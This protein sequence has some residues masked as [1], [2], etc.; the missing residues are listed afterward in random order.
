MRRALL[1]TLALGVAPS[2][3]HAGDARAPRVVIDA[4]HGG[5]Q[6]GAVGV[7]GVVEK[8]VVLAVAHEAA[9]LLTDAGWEVVLTRPDDRQVGL[10]ERVRLANAAGADLFVSIHCNA[11]TGPGSRRV[12]GIETYFLSADATDEAARR[13]ARYENQNAGMAPRSADD[14]LSRILH[15]LAVSAAHEGSA[16]LAGALQE[17]L[18]AAMGWPD[19]GVRQAPFAVLNGAAMPAVLVELGFL[20]HPSEGQQLAEAATQRRLAEALVAGLA[21]ARTKLGLPA[22]TGRRRLHARR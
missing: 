6:T 12:R 15:D 5:R 16:R 22:P 3:A 11:Y 4:G 10:A 17:A 1:V 9:R 18:V 19:R 7:Q 20:T 14:P 21:A 2:L 8:E 13:L